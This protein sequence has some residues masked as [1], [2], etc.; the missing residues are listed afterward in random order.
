MTIGRR[1]FIKT[2]AAFGAAGP[3][4]AQ[5]AAAPN[6]RVGILSDIHVTAL[7]NADWFEKALRYFDGRK[8]DAVFIAG[9]LTTRNKLPEFEAVATTWFKVF[10]GD[11]RSDGAPVVRLF[12]TG[13]HDVDG[14]ATAGAKFKTREEAEPVSFFFHR[15]EFWRRLFHEGYE[16]ICARTVKGYTFILRNW[17][18]R[19]GHPKLKA[20]DKYPLAV[21]LSVEPNPAPE[22]LA[23]TAPTLPGDRPFFY[24][25]H[26]PLC[27][28]VNLS[29]GRP[30]DD[31]AKVLAAFPNALALSG[32]SH[33]SLTDE[34]SIWQG[35][36]TAVNCSCARGYAFT[37]PGREN[38]HSTADAN[39]K[40]PFEMGMFDFKRVKQGMVM[41]VYD[42]R[43]T[44]HRREFVCDRQLGPDW[45]VPLF[46]G[47]TVPQNGT[48][49]YDFAA[50]AAAARAP[51]FPANAEVSV[52][53]IDN[54]HRRDKS[55]KKLDPKPR[56]QVIVSFPPVV[57]GA[58]SPSRGFEFTVTAEMRV[59]DKTQTVQEKRVFSPNAYMAEEEDVE[60]VTCAFAR[61]DIPKRR[62]VRFVVH[63]IDCWGNKGAAIASPWR[64][65]ST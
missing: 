35:A 24:A 1:D 63:P 22:F 29:S 51:V 19:I 2:A 48:P 8:V 3:A 65:F 52:A 15:D 55:G 27:G 6:L 25:Q 59:A 58:V 61:A 26:E 40:P 11:R 38:G 62:D 53:E 13:N 33:F 45:T 39:R 56:K 43:I 34:R 42:D 4:L 14:F 64:R 44:F 60:P 46:G 32:H 20:G 57:T 18:S 41:D 30:F 9:D 7:S 23:K 10:P 28:T 49:K 21:G 36:F 54:G 50:R 5:G 31:T 12:I 47:R 17:H 37:P 16:P